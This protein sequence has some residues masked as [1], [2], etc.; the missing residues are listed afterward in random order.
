[1]RLLALSFTLCFAVPSFCLSQEVANK[2]ISPTAAPTNV[3]RCQSDLKSAEVA[4]D[5]W[6][7]LYDRLDQDRTKLEKR[8]K[9]LEAGNVE[10]A[11]QLEELRA[12]ARNVLNYSVTLDAEYRKLSLLHT[13]LIEKYNGALEQANEQL[14]TANARL[15]RQNRINNALAIYSAMPKYT[16]IQLTPPPVFN[17]NTFNCRTNTIGSTT[18][19]NCN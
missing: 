11:K 14:T 1:M 2:R 15:S 13:S 5:S 4:R 16:P 6:N 19:T 17:N 10:L 7:A 12:A 3:S 9:E 18:Y 8:N